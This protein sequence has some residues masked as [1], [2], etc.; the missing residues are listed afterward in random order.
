VLKQSVHH[1]VL[2]L[3]GPNF[4]NPNHLPTFWHFWK[5]CFILKSQDQIT[6]VLIK[7]VG[8][9]ELL[10][11]MDH[12]KEYGK[13]QQD[14]LLMLII[15]STIGIQMNFAK[16]G[17]TLHQLMD[18]HLI[19]L[20]KEKINKANLVSNVHSIHRQAFDMLCD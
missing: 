5:K 19:W 1:V 14:L 2:L 3:P 8:Y 13:G 6:F 15:I 12:G 11:E 17:V 10:T 4:Q 18:L 9:F 7:H 20:L 16:N